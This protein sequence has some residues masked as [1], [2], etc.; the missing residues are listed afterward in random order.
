MRFAPLRWVALFTA[1]CVVATGCTLTSSAGPKATHVT[2]YFTRTIAF[3]AGSKVKLM[4]IDV[5]TVDS[6]AI[7]GTKVRVRF[8]VDPGVPL[9]ADVHAAIQ[10]LSLIGERN[11]TLFPPW[12]P[13]TPRLADGSVIPITRTQVPVEVDEILKAVT[14]LADSLDP[15]EVKGFVTG[16]A[17]ALAGQGQTLNDTLEQVA[18]VTGTLA[19]QDAQ[20]IEIAGNIQKLA[21]TLNA[22]QQQLGTVIDDFSQATQ[23]LADER[24]QLTSFLSAITQLAQ[25]GQILLTGVQQDLPGDLATLAKVVLTVQVNAGGLSEFLTA[26]RGVALAVTNAYEPNLKTLVVRVTLTQS[27]YQVLLP[28]LGALGITIPCLPLPGQTCPGGSG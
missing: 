23:I 1:M 28:V 8:T 16:S 15:N 25:Q 3:Y 10:P 22:R 26:L 6:V 12:M 24:Q 5:G 17:A 27:A 11:L 20:L 4:G 18:G 7:A 19:Q 13:G 9:R 21:A 14:D 2:A